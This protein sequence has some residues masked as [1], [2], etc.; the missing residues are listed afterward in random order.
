[1]VDNAKSYE[2]R[3]REAKTDLELGRLHEKLGERVCGFCTSDR[4][5]A[6]T[7]LFDERGVYAS[8]EEFDVCCL[9]WGKHT[10]TAKR[11]R[12]KPFTRS[13]AALYD[14]GICRRCQDRVRDR[15]EGG[16]HDDTAT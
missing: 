3:S 11:R 4:A 7:E 15:E 1:L 10:P 2:L 16:K 5:P 9:I 6:E 12:L 8:E 14:C 13:L